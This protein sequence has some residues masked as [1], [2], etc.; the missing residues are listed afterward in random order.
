[1]VGTL[2]SKKMYVLLCTRL[3]VLCLTPWLY[4]FDPVTLALALMDD[5]SVGKGK[6]FKTF[7]RM[8][9]NLDAALVSIVDGNYFL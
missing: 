5:S 2:C 3:W 6:D 9:Q 4:K 8:L 1:M 7:V